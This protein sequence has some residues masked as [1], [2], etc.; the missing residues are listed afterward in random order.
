M[1]VIIRAKNEASKVFGEVD[2]GMGGLGKT[3]AVGAGISAAGAAGVAM[4]SG[5]AASANEYG[6]QVLTVQRLTGLSAEA[7]S[8]A[9][10]LLS[11][12]GIQGT[13]AGRVF[14][15]LDTAIVG[16]NKS[17]IEAGIATQNADGSNR[18]AMDVL[19]D[20]SDYYSTA[21]DKT[22][23][24]AL[25]SKVLGK[26]YMDLLPILAGGSSSIEKVTASAQ[27]NGLVLSQEQIG[28]VQKYGSAQKDNQV[29]MQGL[30]FQIGII[31][32]PAL[33]QLATKTGELFGWYSRL[34]P[35]MKS[36]VGKVVLFAA[37]ASVLMVPLGAILMAL[38][39]LAA[40]F[41]T[42]SGAV[43]GAVGI[44]SGPAGLVIAAGAAGFAIGTLL[45]KLEAVQA[46]QKNVGGWLQENW[47]VGGSGAS[48]VE[49]GPA[50]LAAQRGGATTT[51]V[52]L[53]GREISRGLGKTV[54]ATARSGAR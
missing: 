8:E 46:M 7:S 48:T 23:A 11:R 50:I 34:D 30:S 21:T 12:Y 3:A 54:T 33:T 10:A 31:L 47:G 26:G 35:S 9:A 53:D 1:E 14:K 45:N 6:K 20:L 49:L 44:L 18:G 32:L 17:L 13:Q 4:F 22:A 25:A 52:Y 43:S 5:M 19:A 24:T 37:G 15:S 41:G 28:I 29:A 16:H 39:A 36:L 42:L 40:G 2:K 27:K 51:K 38:P